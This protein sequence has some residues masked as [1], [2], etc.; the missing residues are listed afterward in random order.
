MLAERAFESGVD[1]RVIGDVSGHGDTGITRHWIGSYPG[2]EI[3][4]GR[5]DAYE[6]P[7]TG[8]QLKAIKKGTQ[9]IHAFGEISYVDAFNARRLTRYR[10]YYQGVGADIGAKIGL[11]YHGE[12]NTE[13]PCPDAK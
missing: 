8:D 5:R 7:L 4:W 9:A 1:L 13:V 10:F 12:G 2:K 6:Q 3:M 11:T